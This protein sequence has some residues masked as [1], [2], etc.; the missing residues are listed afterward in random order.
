MQ[1]NVE[2]KR[3]D[4]VTQRDGS[5]TIEK[6]SCTSLLSRVHGKRR[7]QYHATKQMRHKMYRRRKDA[8]E[9]N[10]LLSS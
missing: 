8:K 3:E 6:H 2:R 4:D 9:N 7:P 5:R 1:R 10:K